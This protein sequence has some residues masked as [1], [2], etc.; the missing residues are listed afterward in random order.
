MAKKTLS[1]SV[2][3]QLLSVERAASAAA[4]FQTE[5][6]EETK[7]SELGP[8]AASKITKLPDFMLLDDPSNRA[9]YG[10]DPDDDLVESMKR[11][12]FQGLI[13]AYPDPDGTGK[14]V[15]ESGHRRRAA[16]KKAGLAEYD[17]YVTQPPASDW[18]R[19]IRLV[20][21][22]LHGRKEKP[23][24]CARVAA[25]LFD[26]HSKELAEKRA[27]GTA[28]P[29]EPDNVNELVALD[30]GTSRAT[31]ERYRAFGKLADQLRALGDSGECSWSELAGAATLD[32]GRQRALAEAIRERAGEKGSE[33]VT[34]A[35]LREK[36]REEKARMR[37]EEAGGAAPAERPRSAVSPQ[38]R[39][40]GAKAVVK[41]TEALA[42]MLASPTSFKEEEKYAVKASLTKLKAAIDAAIAGL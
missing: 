14:Y 16:A 24:V 11:Y 42:S 33:N 4:T 21:H 13:I 35:W 19:T 31:V 2:A 10:D 6:T 40:Y 7:V 22:N 12:G 3:K 5:V 36:I 38:V 9:L 26:A 18:E 17:V 34:R 41:G 39:T 20:T 27:A 8:E 25:A 1:E 23:S 32:V 30:M 15:I 29:D 28:A 37:M